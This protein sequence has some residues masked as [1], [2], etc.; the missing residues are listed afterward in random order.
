MAA[1]FDRTE[2]RK[3]DISDKKR[4]KAVIKKSNVNKD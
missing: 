4:N 2:M 1:I 3:G